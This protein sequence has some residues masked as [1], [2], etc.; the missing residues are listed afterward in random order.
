MIKIKKPFPFIIIFLTAI[1]FV[2]QFVSCSKKETSHRDSITIA[3]ES[4][5]TNFDPRKATDVPSSRIVQ[6]VY[7]GLV[8]FNE[9][10]EIVPDL[11]DK[12]DIPDSNKYVFHIR[13]GVKFHNGEDLKAE[14]VEYTFKSI[15]DPGFK[16]PLRGSYTF[17]K[18]VKVLDDYT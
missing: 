9:K 17:L 1:S 3:F 15:L 11:S 7:S 5:P 18:D 14:D 12:W 6:I 4:A 2:F 8:R 10:S 13:R 16:S